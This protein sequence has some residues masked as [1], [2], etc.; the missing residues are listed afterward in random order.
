MPVITTLF[1]CFFDQ[2]LVEARTDFISE[3]RYRLCLAG[4]LGSGVIDVMEQIATPLPVDAVE[5]DQ[6]RKQKS[7]C[8]A[9]YEAV[10][11]PPEDERQHGADRKDEEGVER[12]IER[13]GEHLV[14]HL[15][16][17]VPRNQPG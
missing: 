12:D 14:S 11:D 6:T 1:I 17:E 16:D 13:A 10:A 4:L 8:Q 5:D 7:P 2:Y 3:V 15:P 9:S